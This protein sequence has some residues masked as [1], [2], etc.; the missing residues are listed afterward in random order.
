VGVCSYWLISY[1]FQ[2]ES[3]AS[4][5][6][7]AFIYN[8]I[9]DV[10]FLLAMFLIFSKAGS[11]DYS[12]IFAHKDLIG[13]ASPRPRACSCPRGLRK[14]AQIPLFNWLPDAMAGP[15]A[16]LGPHPPLPP[17]SRRGLP[18]VSGE[19]ILQLSPDRW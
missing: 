8:R 2:S 15:D 5:A 13:G 16:G 11:L 12:V 17:W 14:S 1:W 19:S 9:G 10:G 6:K 4:A 18:A 7:K 3:N